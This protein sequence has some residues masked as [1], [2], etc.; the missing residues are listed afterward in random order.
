MSRGSSPW[1]ENPRPDCSSCQDDTP[2]SRRI[3]RAPSIPSAAAAPLEVAEARV[4][5]ADAVAERGQALAGPR[6]RLAGRC[7]GRAGVREQPLS[8]Q[9]R[10]RVTAHSHRRI[11]HPSLVARPQEKRDLVDEHRNVNR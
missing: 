10:L 3:E 8:V 6:E 4:R 2:R 9:D 11:D 7:P 5:E 1:N